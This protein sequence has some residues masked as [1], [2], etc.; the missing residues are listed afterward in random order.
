MLIWH[1]FVFISWIMWVAISYFVHVSKN[2]TYIFPNLKWAT[3]INK[4]TKK[5]SATLGFLR[6]NLSKCPQM[7]RRTAYFSLVRL[8]MAQQDG[9]LISTKNLEQ[10][11]RKAAPFITWDFKSREPG[12]MTKML[13]N[14]Q[15]PTLEVRRKKNRL[16]SLF[17]ISKGLVPAIPPSEYL[18]PI[19][20]TKRKRKAKSFQNYDTKSFVTK[21]QNLLDNLFWIP[22]FW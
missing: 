9:T 3:H 15:L 18:I 13:N 17:K 5:A 2:T 6:R 22:R 14:I 19:K 20:Q 16:C 21:H 11:L 7:C 1:S 8:N 4:I 12:S 10:I